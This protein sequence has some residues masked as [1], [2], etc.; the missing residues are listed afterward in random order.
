MRVHRVIPYVPGALPQTTEEKALA[1]TGTHFLDRVQG[2]G[3]RL[4]EARGAVVLEFLQVLD[5]LAQL[6]RGVDHQRVE[7]QDQQGQLPVHPHQDCRSADQRQHGHQETTEGFADELVQGV[8]VGDQVRG[9][10]AA[11]Q[12]FVFL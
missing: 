11:A 1:V 3:Q 7:Q 5:P 10:R 2:F 12:A 9:H 6:H 8:Q 4:G